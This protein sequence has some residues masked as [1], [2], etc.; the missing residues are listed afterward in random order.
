[1]NTDEI[2]K[3][4]QSTLDYDLDLEDRIELIKQ[5]DLKYGVLLNR[6]YIAYAIEGKKGYTTN[7]KISNYNSLMDALS[8]YLLFA[9]NENETEEQK[10]NKKLYNY[11]Q[12]SKLKD[13]KAESF[14][15][16]NVVANSIRKID[17]DETRIHSTNATNKSITVAHVLEHMTKC[18]YIMPYIKCSQRMMTLI[19]YLEKQ[20]EECKKNNKE[21]IAK[22]TNTKTKHVYY[23]TEK[24]VNAIKRGFGYTTNNC[25]ELNKDVIAI[26]DSF[27]QPFGAKKQPQA[28][29]I[30]QKLEVD[31]TDKCTVKQLI[32]FSPVAGWSD[33]FD[34]IIKQLDS[35]A[36][37]SDFTTRENLIYGAFRRGKMH[38]QDDNDMFGVVLTQKEVGDVLGIDRRRV[39]QSLDGMAH[40]I[41]QTYKKDLEEYIYTFKKRGK[42]KKCSVCNTNKL[43]SENYFYFRKDTQK[44]ENICKKCKKE[45]K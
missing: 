39:N 2:I 28:F 36:D 45:Q 41:I 15:D 34:N 31:L 7:G 9:K 13:G 14:I 19:P 24:E 30:S 20:I 40:K 33:V 21:P 43:E 35:L 1:M 6:S 23:Y 42:Y 3:E 11:Y 18:D 5:I 38:K 22:Y 32:T 29:E 8:D 44:F 12:E 25:S 27:Y 17:Y 37:R 4:V 16:I 26:Y 10:E